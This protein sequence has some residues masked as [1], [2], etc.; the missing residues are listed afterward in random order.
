MPFFRNGSFAEH[1]RG[2]GSVWLSAYCARVYHEA[3]YAEWD[4]MLFIDPNI[5]KQAMH[6]VLHHQVLRFGAQ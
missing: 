3:I 5:I 6:F 4:Y 1:K 2:R